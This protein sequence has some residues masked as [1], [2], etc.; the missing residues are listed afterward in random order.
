[1]EQTILSIF[2]V[3]VPKLKTHVDALV[4]KIG[5]IKILTGKLEKSI[6][7]LMWNLTSLRFLVEKHVFHYSNVSNET[8]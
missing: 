2:D 4:G 7:K 5:L 6:A 3:N 1:V 8:F